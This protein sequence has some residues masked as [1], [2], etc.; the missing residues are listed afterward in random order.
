MFMSLP[1]PH[2][3]AV[4]ALTVFALI[5]FTRDRIP[6]E[7]S[8][9]AILMILA[10][11][12][13]LFPYEGAQGP[14]DPVDFFHGFG[15]EALVAVTALM[16]AGHG[17]VRTGALE[18]VGRVFAGLW[19]INP[20]LSL[21]V[22]LYVSAVLS[23]FINNTPIVVLLLPILVN[24]SLRTKTSTSG[25][26]M[27][28]G[29]ATLIGGTGTTIGTSTNLLVVGV[30]ADMGLQ[31]MEMFDFLMPAAIAGSVGMLYLWLIAPRLLPE[32]Q[33]TLA[34]N[35]PRVFAAHLRIPE[36]NPFI[37]QR[38]SD[39]IAK[40]NGLM[41]V[42]KV[43]RTETNVLLPLPD[44]VLRAGDR[45]LVHDTPQKLKEYE[46]LLGA[47]LYAGEHFV[48]EE[49]PLAEPDQQLAEIIVFRGSPLADRSAADVRLTEQFGA[50]ILAIHRAGTEL[51]AMPKGVLNV[52]L[53]IGDVLLIQG[54][55]EGISKL[56]KEADYMVL[57]STTDLPFNRKAPMASLTMLAIVLVSAFGIL[58]ISI[59]APLGVLA[60]LLCGCIGWRDIGQAVNAQVILIIVASLALG[61]ALLLTGGS[62]FLANAFVS[63]S[64]GASPPVILSA[65]IF[66]MAVLTNMVSNNAAAVIGTPV[67]IGIASSLN[68][69]PEP[70]VLAVIF[71]ANLS[72]ATPMA[73][74]TNLL[75]MS[76]GNYTFW[77][78]VRVGV[79]LIILMWLTFS[80]L[81][82]Y[83]Y[84]M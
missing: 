37:G 65:L 62:D 19:K 6:L 80:F 71:G 58:P 3:L 11:G 55:R 69:P 81:L 47:N 64:H 72:F 31:R 1:D 78:F 66:L 13:Q 45:L 44:A 34:D 35:S 12:F 74:Q 29:F 61:N 39:A 2:A 57:D 22:T 48:D 36:E 84:P 4:L 16:I 83:L 18:P 60:M 42:E 33:P 27:P 70:F 17:L 59:S 43:R 5:L 10:V 32:R 8:A 26:L 82:P 25:V 53:R 15:H 67:A 28:M 21:L 76:A 14:V 38:L 54:N 63:L 77:D 68:L 9:F 73:Y 52:R 79:P 56:R 40:T 24:I 7:T 23:G 30:A 46:T 51:T 50:A 20:T 75:V 41:K 49:H